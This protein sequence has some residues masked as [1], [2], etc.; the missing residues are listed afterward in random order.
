[1]WR[2]AGGAFHG[3]HV[4]HAYMEE[5]KFL[6]FMRNL[7]A[8]HD[9]RTSELL[10]ANNSQVQRRRE[11]RDLVLQLIAS[12]TIAD[13]MGDVAEDIVEALKRLG[14]GDL[15][16]QDLSDLGMELGKLGVTTLHGTSLGD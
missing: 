6:P 7:L 15:E 3:P 13:H 16:W 11:M 5:A 9:R 2:A 10:E 14:L 4:E 1:M 8:E 12:L